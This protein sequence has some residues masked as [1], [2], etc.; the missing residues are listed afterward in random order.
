MSDARQLGAVDRAV[1]PWQLTCM[2]LKHCSL[3][4]HVDM[5]LNGLNSANAA[6]RALEH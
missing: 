6:D 4:T 3:C 5:A 1:E 2:P